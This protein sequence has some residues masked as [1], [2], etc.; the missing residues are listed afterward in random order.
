MNIQKS[1][2]SLRKQNPCGI[3]VGVF[4]FILRANVFEAQD[5]MKKQQFSKKSAGFWFSE[6]VVE[7]KAA[8]NLRFKL[9]PMVVSS[10]QNASSPCQNECCNGFSKMCKS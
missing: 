4:H 7:E 6:F 8:G 10:D 1:S 5:E 3:A 2:G 9:S